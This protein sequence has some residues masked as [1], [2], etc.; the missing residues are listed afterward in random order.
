MQ[1]GTAALD[2]LLSALPS[3]SSLVALAI[4]AKGVVALGSGDV[5][6]ATRVAVA[7]SSPAA[8]QL[9]SVRAFR[10][11]IAGIA[12]GTRVG[13]AN[14]SD[15]SSRSVTMLSSIDTLAYTT[16]SWLAVR[17]ASLAV[18]PETSSGPTEKGTADEADEEDQ[19]LFAS[20][21]FTTDA[22]ASSADVSAAKADTEAFLDAQERCVETLVAIGRK[23]AGLDGLSDSGTEQ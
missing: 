12:A 20:P 2:D 1:T 17:Q 15:P 3:N 7:V 16:I 22:A 13:R 23:A 6:S 14:I 4:L 19:V 5:I 8:Q 21:I 18:R 9:E 10:E 11:L